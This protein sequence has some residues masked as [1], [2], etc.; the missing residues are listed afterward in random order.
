MR[1]IDLIQFAISELRSVGIEEGGTDVNQLLGH[2]LG[3]SRT[4]L[5]LA[6]EQE[7]PEKGRQIFLGLLARR[8][9]REPLA[10]ILGEREFWSLPFSVNSAVLIPRP[11][12]EFLLEKALTSAR[13]GTCPGGMILDLCCGSGV[14]AVV[15]ALELGG[16]IT[17]V[18]ISAAAL[19]VAREN[20]TR[21]GV[22]QRVGLIQAD[23]LNAF[24]PRRTFSLVVSNPPYV[25]R[26]DVLQGL[27]PEVAKF[28]PH[29][30]LDGGEQGLDVIQRIRDVL[31]ACMLPGGELFMEIGS[32][33]GA[34]VQKLFSEPSWPISNFKNVE[35]LK[36]YAG[37]DRVLHATAI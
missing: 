28:E 22:S 33:Q 1:I 37:R 31:P 19:E 12:T 7:V 10:Y 18:D 6:A 9:K 26:H 21:H 3:K 20:C 35:I 34:E 17:A 32:D 30:A 23:L 14:I 2:C 4:E 25:S 11:E 8:K 29:L 16:R 13:S 24:Q 5:F 15:L 27:E 36:D